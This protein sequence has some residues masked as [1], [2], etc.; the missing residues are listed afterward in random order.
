[1]E[2]F[3]KKIAKLS[4]FIVSLFLIKFLIIKSIKIKDINEL[5]NITQSTVLFFGDSHIERGIK[6]S[7]DFRNLAKS[8]QPLFFSCVQAQQY[9]NKQGQ[10]SIAIS[11]DNLSLHHR[12]KLE[13]DG[14]DDFFQKYFIYLTI[15]EHLSLICNFPKKWLRTFFGLGLRRVPNFE[16]EIGYSPLKVDRMLKKPTNILGAPNVEDI[17]VAKLIQFIDFNQNHRIYLIR[18]P[19]CLNKID[20]EKFR[21]SEF[22]FR[23]IINKIKSKY[24][25][26]QF[27]D[28]IDNFNCNS[29]LFYDW[30]HLNSNGADSLNVILKNHF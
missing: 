27:L 19:L 25:N 18:M 2:F 9:C 20:P 15:G 28:Y 1:M 29:G 30:D 24:K 6:E 21:I 16:E 8:A 26:V 11:F 7:S 12:N 14:S 23:N 5:D 13:S 10:F 3:L 22:Y 17:N 4:L